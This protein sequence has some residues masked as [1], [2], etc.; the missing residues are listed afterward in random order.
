[1]NYYVKPDNSS[2]NKEDKPKIV[3]KNESKPASFTSIV[4][5]GEDRRKNYRMNSGHRLVD[6]ITYY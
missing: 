4:N 3:E 2:M 6:L 5:R 1:M